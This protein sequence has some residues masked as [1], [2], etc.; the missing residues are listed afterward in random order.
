MSAIVRR[1]VP[2]PP[3]AELI[4]TADEPVSTNV[5]LAMLDQRARARRAAPITSDPGLMLGPGEVSEMEK[6]ISIVLL[7]H[8]IWWVVCVPGSIPEKSIVSNRAGEPRLRSIARD[9]IAAIE[10]CI[11][12]FREE[13]FW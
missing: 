7:D 6:A 4:E 8:L 13:D 12:R 3:E 10:Y 2:S 5:M 11:Q 9:A 1:F